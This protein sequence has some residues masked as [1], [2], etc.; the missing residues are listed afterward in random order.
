MSALGESEDLVR[1]LQEVGRRKW[2]RPLVDGA[3]VQRRVSGPA[4]VP[5]ALQATCYRAALLGLLAVAYLEYYFAD[6]LLQVFTL[7]SL[8]V[9][10]LVG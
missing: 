8:I 3:T 1:W 5:L 2:P 9:F 6:V 4:Q 10:I 7:P